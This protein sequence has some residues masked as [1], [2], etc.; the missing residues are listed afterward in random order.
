MAK[1]F[2]SKALHLPTEEISRQ[3]SSEANRAA[4]H[5]YDT[6]AMV[7]LVQQIKANADYFRASLFETNPSQVSKLHTHD[8]DLLAFEEAFIPKVTS[9]HRARE[10]SA[11]SNLNLVAILVE[12]PSQWYGQSFEIQTNIAQKTCLEFVALGFLEAEDF[13]LGPAFIIEDE[14]GGKVDI[15]AAYEARYPDVFSHLKPTAQSEAPRAPC[16]W[17]L[18][19]HLPLQSR[20][21]CKGFRAAPI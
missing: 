18:H 12:R 1:L 21:L 3:N 6:R 17:A 4:G 11:K 16:E 10:A 2:R 14:D 19:R 9:F 20:R 8:R 7:E 13:G 5:V 15:L